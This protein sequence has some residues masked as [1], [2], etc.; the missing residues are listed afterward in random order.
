MDFH[1][2][3]QT[4]LT[5]NSAVDQSP[6]FSPDGERIAFVGE[7]GTDNEIFVMNADGS[8]PA[9][10]TNNTEQ[11]F[12]PSFSPDGNRIVLAREVG[13]SEE[14][15][16]FVINSDGSNETPLT[17][18]LGS[19]LDPAWSPDQLGVVFS[20]GPP[21]HVEGPTGIVVMDADG[22]NPTPL[23][24][25][26]LDLG[27]A[28]APNG[29]RIAFSRAT[30]E[31]ANGD[32]FLMDSDGQNQAPLTTDPGDEADPDW[33]PLNPPA[34]QL[35]GP[36]KQKS[37]GSVVTTVTCS[38]DA[39][40]LASGQGKAP[41]ALKL[42]AASKAKKFT[43]EPTTIEVPPDQP[44]VLILAVP[45][46]GKKA[47]KNAAKAGKKGKATVTATATDDLGESAQDSLAVKFKKR[48][49]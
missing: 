29:Q 18:N 9:P 39:T 31:G 33:Q 10:V 3:N 16:I 46:K 13:A 12:S 20:G 14:G 5:F 36:A 28:F 25:G 41:K 21:V 6:T 1:G 4:Q 32:I 22:Q 43:L 11:D 8:N 40:V 38:E 7:D 23:T 47:L 44:T 35:T 17:D 2:E 24:T 30:G 27:A 45:K 49:K 37:F 15:E 48:K 42:A 34:C 19:D 26:F